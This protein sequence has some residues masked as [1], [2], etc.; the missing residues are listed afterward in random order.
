MLVA[1]IG[2]ILRWQVDFTEYQVVED[3]ED[4]EYGDDDDD[5]DLD[6]FL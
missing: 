4:E 5:I 6:A 3:V 1:G 2:G